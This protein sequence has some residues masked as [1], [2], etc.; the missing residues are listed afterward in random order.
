M[1]RKCFIDKSK[2]CIRGSFGLWGRRAGE[3]MR[4]KEGH[5][6]PYPQSV[7]K[8]GRLRVILK[9]I[10]SPWLLSFSVCPVWNF[11]L[12]LCLREKA[13]INTAQYLPCPLVLR[14]FFTASL[15]RSYVNQNVHQNLFATLSTA[16][17]Y[18]CTCKQ[19]WRAKDSLLYLKFPYLILKSTVLKKWRYNQAASF[20]NQC[21]QLVYLWIREMCY[22]C[23]SEILSSLFFFLLIYTGVKSHTLFIQN[24]KPSWYIFHSS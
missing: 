20:E 17:K 6:N 14:E 22:L 4:G 1:I 8:Y 18:T 19:P 7:T 21:I 15:L 13:V 5:G 9:S 10:R 11:C 24:F 16:C 12:I 2:P 23:P 3:C